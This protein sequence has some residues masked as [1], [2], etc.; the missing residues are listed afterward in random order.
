LSQVEA[1]Q[2]LQH[3][4]ADGEALSAAARKAP[5]AHIDT[6]PEWHM[7]DL[8][9]H[10]ARVHRWANHL[11]ATRATTYQ[12][13]PESPVDDFDRL[14]IWYDE[15]LAQLLA[16]LEGTDPDAEVWNWAERGAGRA[17]FWARRMAHE[18]AVHR[19][20]G[21]TAAGVA[22]PISRPL[23]VDGIDEYLGFVT[24]WLA[25]DP[26]ADLEGS[27][28]LHATDGDGEWSMQLR[29]EGLE[30]VR[31]HRKADAAI[32]APASDLLLWLTNRVPADSPGFQ[33]F[34]QR[35]LI[36]LWSELKF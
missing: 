36:D 14:M 28:H 22:Q 11:V 3:L 1:D 7:P 21:E 8:V 5:A 27:L 12:K 24:R 26:I 31:E 16:T 2:Y 13:G 18:T 10:V 23:A 33:V 15:G 35:E 19:W 32:R 9:G 20:D 4:Q 6:C 30:L 34:G 25:R 29:P 17:R